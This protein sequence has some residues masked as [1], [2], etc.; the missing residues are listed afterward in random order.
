MEASLEILPK[1]EELKKIIRVPSILAVTPCQNSIDFSFHSNLKDLSCCHVCHAYLSPYCKINT[2]EYNSKNGVVSQPIN[3]ECQICGNKNK[4]GIKKEFNQIQSNNQNY[5]CIYN[6]INNDPLIYAIYLSTDFND[7][8][9]LIG[10]KI[11]C[12][13]ILRHMNQDSQCL[14]FIGSDTAEYSILV[15]QR[16]DD[17][18]K[19][20]S[21]S[22]T[23]TASLARFSSIN[24]FIGLDLS[25]FFFNVSNESMAE[26][27]IEKLTFSKDQQP[28]LKT[29]EISMT[30]SRVLEGR[31]LRTFSVLCS[32]GNK[33]SLPLI[34]EMRQSLLRVDFIVSGDEYT[35]NTLSLSE[36]VQGVI[37]PLSMNN[38]ALQALL[39]L[40]QETS[41]RLLMR[42]QAKMCAVEWKKMHRPYS[43]MKDTQLFAPVV[44]NNE[45]NE[46]QNNSNSSSSA[47]A[48]ELKPLPNQEKIIVQI[49]A[50]FVKKASG[51]KTLYVLRVFNRVF[52]T[53]DSFDEIV[54]G[55]NWNVSLWFWSRLLT[56]KPRSECV[57]MI[58]RAA[59]S[60][61]SEFKMFK[62]QKNKQTQVD[63]QILKNQEQKEK[64]NEE[65]PNNKLVSNYQNFLR[66]VCAF[67]D[68][69]LVSD[70]IEDRWIGTE[71]LSLMKPN[72]LCFV[73]VEEKIGNLN[74]VFSPNGACFMKKSENTDEAGFGEKRKDLIEIQKRYP[75]YIPFDILKRP[76]GCFLNIDQERLEK[77]QDL[78]K[79]LQV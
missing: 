24:S 25:N 45:N 21:T 22:N 53:S 47:F 77:L 11:F 50:R 17:Q 51:N 39:L 62:N 44:I 37:H 54:A 70:D 78:T 28:A 30:L 71:L 72:Q 29:Y 23:A 63:I 56:Y 12:C 40:K 10:A 46:N 31:Q 4:F 43:E 18:Y 57:A 69:Y 33:N 68:L 60:V 76:P 26:R 7:N 74:V 58:F 8:K 48:L 20:E 65:T 35:K 16:D 49:A 75:L 38:P 42:C 15:P 14:I 73:P 1:N 64:Q 79:Q 27:A 13:S 66:A 6:E 19:N 3:W 34:E 41:Y 9:S 2:Q 61:L 55:I 59:A 32:L 52:N 67:P 36:E 5:E